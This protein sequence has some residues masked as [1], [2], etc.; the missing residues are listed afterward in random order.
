MSENVSAKQLTTAQERAALLVAEDTLTDQQIAA[1]CG[2][3]DRTIWRWKKLAVFL[4]AVDAHRTRWRDEIEQQG[5]A[6]RK[7]RVDALN[8]RWRLMRQV[9]EERA[10]SRDEEAPGAGTGLLVRQIKS[11]GFGENN[12]TVE[13]YTVDTGLLKELRAH[14]EQAAKELGQ[15][16]EKHEHTGKD[17]ESLVFT[18]QIDRAYGDSDDSGL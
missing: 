6:N 7:N 18:I 13:E 17:G 12:Q 5:I 4:A 15:W 2:V 14:E 1:A 11:I 10:A 3:T 16:L 9:I 8:E